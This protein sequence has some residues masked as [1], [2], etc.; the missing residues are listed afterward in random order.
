MDQHSKGTKS[1]IGKTSRF[2]L[3]FKCHVAVELI[4]SRAFGSLII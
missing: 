2:P 3:L 4:A 1:F